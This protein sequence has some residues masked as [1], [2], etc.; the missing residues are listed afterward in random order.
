M[1]H[2]I[3]VRST[4]SCAVTGLEDLESLTKESKSVAEARSTIASLA[5]QEPTTLAE[6][7]SCIG[8]LVALTLDDRKLK[9]LSVRI[10][11][12]L[13]AASLGEIGGCLV[14]LD[15]AFYNS[16]D[17]G[18][19]SGALMFDEVVIAAPGLLVLESAV[20]K[21]WRTLDWFPSIAQLLQALREEDARWHYWLRCVSKALDEHAQVLAKLKSARTRLAKTDE[22]RKAERQS[23][24]DALRRLQQQIRA[25][26]PS[27][28]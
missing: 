13:R 15:K 7:D 8:T 1:T 3:P 9:E 20:R 22:E 26:A 16:R 14:L 25:S 27:Y 17:K 21:L 23:R 5:R 12:G 10:T 28:S 18:E 4:P 19:M 24:L 6:A 11:G 2:L